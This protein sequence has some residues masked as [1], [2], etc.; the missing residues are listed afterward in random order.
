ML[1]VLRERYLPRFACQMNSKITNFFFL[2]PVVGLFQTRPLI[3]SQDVTISQIKRNAARNKLW[4][5]LTIF[6]IELMQYMDIS[7]RVVSYYFLCQRWHQANTPVTILIEYL[8]GIQGRWS[9][10]IKNLIVPHV[11]WLMYTH[12][13]IN[14][15][16]HHLHGRWIFFVLW[17]HSISIYS[18]ELLA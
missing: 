10:T 18:S 17:I 13:H 1:I 11:I 12:A 7:L 3:D 5:F 14:V 15:G 6:G 4:A 16:F 2:F 9:I 8:I